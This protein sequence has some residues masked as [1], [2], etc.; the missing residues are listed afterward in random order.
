M[1]R[2]VICLW[3]AGALT[4][5]LAVG[6]GRSAAQTRDN[7]GAIK[8]VVR[9]DDIGSC[10]TSNLA[11]IKC[12]QEGIVKSVEVQVP[13]P[14]FNEAVKMLRENP[15]LDVGVHLTLTSEWENYKWGPLTQAPSLV[16]AQ[17]NFYP[18]TAQR[19]DFPPNTG[20]LQSGWKIDEV[21]KELRAQIE[22]AKKMIP[23]VSH[24]SS[25]MGTPTAAPE[26]RALV[27]RLAKEYKLPIETPGAKYVSWQA[28]SKAERRAARGRTGQGIGGARAGHLDRDRASGARHAGDAGDGTQGLLGGRL[29]PRRRDEVL[30]QPQGQRGH[31]TTQH[32]VGQLPRHVAGTRLRHRLCAGTGDGTSPHNISQHRPQG[33]NPGS[34]AYGQQRRVQQAPVPVVGVAHEQKRTDVPAHHGQRP[35]VVQRG[36]SQQGQRKHDSRHPR[37]Q[38]DRQPRA[39]GGTHHER[40]PAKRRP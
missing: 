12:Y 9:A 3:L 2:K 15:G 5:A 18:Q 27:Q 35:V 30:H 36:Q 13:C 33:G 23:Q 6:Y 11:C 32:P 24:L 34:Y 10:H 21:E 37:G 26:L 8:L 28:D 25:H 1:N 17:G 7:P 29:A 31:Q 40:P 39:L 20:F 22:L 14:W 38:E 4:V 19:P 16:D